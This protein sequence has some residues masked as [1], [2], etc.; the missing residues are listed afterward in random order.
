M[1]LISMGSGFMIYPPSIFV[2]N[3]LETQKY[4]SE[5]TLNVISFVFNLGILL[6]CI[7]SAVLLF[8]VQ[9]T[10]VLMLGVENSNDLPFE[11]LLLSFA[12][13]HLLFFCFVCLSCVKICV[14]VCVCV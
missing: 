14:C 11:I 6:G 7:Y 2:L 13:I 9:N 5:K 3:L 10:S 8:Y 1:G 4:A 12:G